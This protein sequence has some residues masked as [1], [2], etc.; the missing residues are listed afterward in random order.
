MRRVALLALLVFA[1]AACTARPTGTPGG[2]KVYGPPGPPGPPGTA[3]PAGPPGPPG[4]AGPAGPAGP[5]GAPGVAG[6]PG[7]AGPPGAAGAPGERGAAAK[8]T[9]FRDILFDFDKS[10][11]RASEQSKVVDIATFLKQNPNAEVS[12]EGHADPRGTDSYNLRLS[13]RRV[14]AVRDSLQTAGINSQRIRI[15]AV[16]EKYPACT[17]ATEDCYQ[18]DRRV[19]VFVR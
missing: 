15:G 11:V 8:W 17:E 5:G 14:K 9:S 16:G 7:A 2:W 6:A 1:S 4:P 10:D 13:E 19:A 18:R 12:L 3:G